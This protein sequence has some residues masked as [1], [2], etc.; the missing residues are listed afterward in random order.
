MRAAACVVFVLIGLSSFTHLLGQATRPADTRK[1]GASQPDTLTLS[2]KA[3]QFLRLQREL[4]GLLEKKDY[5]A[6]AAVCG[7]MIDLAPRS[8]DAHYNLACCLAQLEKPAQALDELARAIDNG[9]V[10]AD[11][12]RQ[13]DDLKPLHNEPRFTQLIDKLVSTVKAERDKIYEKG[14]ALP[15]VRTEEGDPSTGLRWRLRMSPTASA[16]QPDRLI[17]WLHPSGASMND[18]VEALAPEL[19]KRGYAL[20]VPTA[21][22]WRGWSMGDVLKFAKQTVAD[23]GKVAG[24][25]ASRPILFGYSAGGQAA[26][27][28][29]YESPDTYG[30]LVLDAAYPIVSGPAGSGRT[31]SLPPPKNPAIKNCP[32]FVL[33][34]DQ[35]PGSRVWILSEDSYRLAGVP[36]TIYFVRDQAH[37]WLF[38]GAQREKL[39]RWLE[40][41]A[42][43]RKPDSAASQPST[44][45][46]PLRF[47]DIY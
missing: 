16:S 34:G 31:L 6:A 30:G 11:H 17:L 14:I 32:L 46:K 41:V 8:G 5:V 18:T 9:F 19:N 35:D 7:K 10:D 38:G 23:A 21:K 40:A 24:I 39:Y 45:R 2:Q 12:I 27:L 26:L 25:D 43:G 1:I 47:E 4:T 29:W 15:G 36:L 42:A 3:D 37:T 22:D 20:L 28:L 13:D 33:L 44:P